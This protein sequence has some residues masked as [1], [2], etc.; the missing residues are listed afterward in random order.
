MNYRTKTYIAADW[1]HDGDA[2]E[3]LYKWKNGKGW[4]LDFPDAH[5]LTQSRDSSLPCSIKASLK[6]R[7]D[8]SKKFV[9]IVGE[10]TNTATK[11]GCQFCDS[12]NHYIG[13]CKKGKTVDA[14]SF[15]KYECDKAYEAGIKIIVLYK[16]VKVNREKCPAVIRYIGEHVPM[17]YTGIDGK[18]YWNYDA[19]KK[20]LEA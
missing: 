11:G 7:M 12:Y 4:S 10:H 13:Y 1:D 18:R 8:A 9:L 15:I 6:T 20:V 14:R 5:E 17:I 16:D 2:V 3:Q 19:V